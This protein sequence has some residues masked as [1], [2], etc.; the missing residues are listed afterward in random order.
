MTS[1][2]KRSNMPAACV[3]RAPAKRIEVSRS[4]GTPSSCEPDVSSCA[5]VASGL[6]SGDGSIEVFVVVQLRPR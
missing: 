1:C 4:R 6:A 3:R 2:G 5:T